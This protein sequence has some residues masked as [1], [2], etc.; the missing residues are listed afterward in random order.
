MSNDQSSE[1]ND[2][3]RKVSRR[4]VLT[5]TGIGIVGAAAAVAGSK[6]SEAALG[7]APQEDEITPSH[8]KLTTEDLNLRRVDEK[9]RGYDVA[10]RPVRHIR[11]T[12]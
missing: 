6:S 2:S 1:D 5:K 11:R 8:K 12:G 10:E 9:P 7:K 4:S 3:D